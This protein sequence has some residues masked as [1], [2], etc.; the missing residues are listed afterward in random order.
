MVSGD[1]FLHAE[2]EAPFAPTCK[3]EAG[4]LYLAER[5]LQGLVR[6]Q[7]GCNVGTGELIL[8]HAKRIA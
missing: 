4:L 8:N 2:P 3:E 1:V 6:I 7:A 5:P